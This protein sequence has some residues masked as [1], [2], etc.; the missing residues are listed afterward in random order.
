MRVQYLTLVVQRTIRHEDGN[1]MAR[2]RG[3]GIED[4]GRYEMLSEEGTNKEGAARIAN[5]GFRP[6]SYRAPEEPSRSESQE[7]ARELIVGGA[8][9]WTRM[10]P[11]AITEGSRSGRVLDVMHL[12]VQSSTLRS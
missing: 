9:G 8:P 11:S 6:Q 5:V 12:G 7:R 10:S 1:S 2:G 3:P 4:D